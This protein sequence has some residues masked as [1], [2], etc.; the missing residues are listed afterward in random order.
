MKGPIVVGTDGSE[1]A[2]VA[3][4]TAIGLAKCFG[5]ELHIVSAYNPV[6]RATT[7]GV[8]GEV[9][10]SINP[11]S[12]VEAVLADA[13]SRARVADVDAVTHAELGGAAEAILD[14]AEQVDAG[15]IVVGNRGITSKSRFI[16]GNVPSKVVHHATCSTY[17]VQT[18]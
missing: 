4:S 17:I 1:T 7:A 3:V 10:S 5:L 14:V 2:A 12:D 9:A 18:S 11:H 8:P 6:G 15:L 13:S 16:L